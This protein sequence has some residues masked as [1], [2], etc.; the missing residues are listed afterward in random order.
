[1]EKEFDT[2]P[3]FD[4]AGQMKIMNGPPRHLGRRQVDDPDHRV[5]EE[6][7]KLSEAPAA[8]N[9][10]SDEYLRLVERDPKLK[11]FANRAN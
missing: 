4:L 11:E 8:S 3:T 5:H 10:V 6:H 2:R 1:M 7:G 9:Y